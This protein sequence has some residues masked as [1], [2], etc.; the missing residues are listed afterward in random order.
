MG[1]PSL[2]VAALLVSGATP[3]VPWYT[4]YENGVALL[5]QGDARGAYSE[6]HDAL[7]ARGEEGLRV[8]TEGIRYVDYLPHLYLAI[9]AFMRGDP[10]LARTH[11]ETAERSGVA[12]R[13]ETG[14][15][16]LE[17]YRVLLRSPSETQPPAPAGEPEARALAPRYTL[18]PRRPP[19]LPAEEIRALA[20]QVLARCGL[21]PH[22]EVTQAPWYFFYEVG[23]ELDARGDPQAALDYLIT[24]ADRRP[25]SAHLAR[26]Y[27]LWFIEYRPYFE[28]GRSHSELGNWECALDALELSEKMG[29]VTSA[30]D[31]YA[32]FREL[33]RQ[34]RTQREQTAPK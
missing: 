2:I 28:I 23:L 19:T 21:P 29:E 20:A 25:R 31:D 15:V 27:G 3:G 1:T 30:D 7:A 4:H 17:A 9:S 22:T 6:L 5:A 16:L 8:H 18:F 34:A 14:S 13:S 26:T 10:A 11:L 24:A 32:R 33:L 12:A